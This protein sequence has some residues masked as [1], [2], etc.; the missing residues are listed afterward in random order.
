MIVPFRRSSP[1]AAAGDEGQVMVTAA[2]VAAMRN[3]VMF[4]RKF[5]VV[6]ID[7][8]KAEAARPD[9]AGPG[10][11][12]AVI[13]AVQR[14]R[15]PGVYP[16]DI[17][18]P[19]KQAGSN[20]QM[21]DYGS[22]SLNLGLRREVSSKIHWGIR[23]SD[24][25]KGHGGAE[26][27]RF[28]WVGVN[29]GPDLERQVFHRFAGFHWIGLILAVTVMAGCEEVSDV[30]SRSKTVEPPAPKV[31]PLDDRRIELGLQLLENGAFPEAQV[32]FEAVVADH[33]DHPRP[34]LLRAIAIQKQGRYAMALE[35]LDA[36]VATP[37]DF[38]GRDSI[39]HFRGWCLFYLG[40]PREAEEA[41]ERH[42]TSTPDSADSAFGRG[43]SLLEV[44]RPEDALDSLDLA[45]EI[46][47]AGPRR[48]RTVGKIWIRRGDALWELG[49]IEE[50]THS[51]HKGVIQF[52][53]HYEGWAKMGRGHERLGDPDK[54]EWARREERHARI[55]VGAPVVP[56]S[57][58]TVGEG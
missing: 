58:E 22:G 50:A 49:R 6:T 56:E 37:A 17:L 52:P 33:P 48:R 57:E 14:H 7:S 41:F 18:W 13:E 43:V 32:A 20:V 29:M 12:Y 45:L 2:P 23:A 44:G 11:G 5:V 42:L 1:E 35:Q 51:F 34:R 16:R 25:A 26:D 30:S 15:S 40:R 36:L 9:L 55:R 8:N 53:D 4:P 27:P 10:P 47:T 21:Q 3:A 54:V 19:V 39:L 28:W 38:E 24:P 31:E 46:E